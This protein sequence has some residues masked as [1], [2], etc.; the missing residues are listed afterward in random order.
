M[1]IAIKSRR[2][3]H[4]EEVFYLYLCESKRVEG[5]VKNTQKYLTSVRD[6]DFV[7]GKYKKI[8]D[9]K[10]SNLSLKERQVLD[11]KTEEILKKI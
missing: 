11:R 5:K 3:K 7:S 4:D 9:D 6:I 1:Y 8:Y 2:N 10:L